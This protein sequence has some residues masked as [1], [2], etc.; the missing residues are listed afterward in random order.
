MRGMGAGRESIGEGN[1]LA[2][3][4]ETTAR[5]PYIHFFI[6]IRISSLTLWLCMRTIWRNENDGEAFDEFVRSFL[7]RGTICFRA[8][9]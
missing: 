2:S 1:K 7:V 6:I 3:E 5:I 4:K 8:S 9:G